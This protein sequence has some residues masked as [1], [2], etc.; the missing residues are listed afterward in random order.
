M[1]ERLLL[2]TC[3]CWLFKEFEFGIFNGGGGG[4]LIGGGGFI[5]NG[6]GGGRFNGGG[7]GRFKG[8]GGGKFN[9]G[10]GGRFNGGGGGK[11]VYPKEDGDELLDGGGGGGGG[12]LYPKLLVLLDWLLSLFVLFKLASNNALA[13]IIYYLFPFNYYF[14][15]VLF[16]STGA[17]CLNKLA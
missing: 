5:F 17:F 15:F 11:F 2:V 10:G 1:F 13:F 3:F 6:G 12:R 14:G 7:G 8:G 16:V 9:E 4:K